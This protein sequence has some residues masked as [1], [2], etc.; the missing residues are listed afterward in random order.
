MRK[1]QVTQ[2]DRKK[3]QNS[4]GQAQQKNYCKKINALHPNPGTWLD[5]NGSRIKVIKAVEVKTNGEPGKILDKNFT[6]ACSENAIQIL[7]LQKEGVR[8]G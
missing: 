5:Y 8:R 2:K 6:I 4:F 7:E 3:S 1:K